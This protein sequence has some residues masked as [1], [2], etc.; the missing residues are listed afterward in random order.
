MD[1]YTLLYLKWIANK[2]LLYSVLNSAPC[3]VPAWMGAGF[4]GAGICVAESLHFSPETIITLL[5]SYITI[6]NVFIVEKKK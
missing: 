3:Y 5:I 4:V 1:M 2:D 6:Q